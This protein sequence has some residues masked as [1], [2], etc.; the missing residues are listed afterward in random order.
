MITGS[1]FCA[2]AAYCC[3]NARAVGVWCICYI[4]EKK[5]FVTFC[6]YYLV[7]AQHARACHSAYSLLAFVGGWYR[8]HLC[9]VVVICCLGGLTSLCLSC[10]MEGLTGCCNVIQLSAAAGRLV[11]TICGVH[12]QFGAW[13]I[14]MRGL[15]LGPFGVTAYGYSNHARTW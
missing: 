8:T 6:P 13:T 11:S 15:R 1:C 2:L 4:L 9:Y 7:A 10:H 3:F 5:L 14:S 12:E